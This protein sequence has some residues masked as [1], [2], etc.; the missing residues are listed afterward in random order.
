MECTL[1]A[2]ANKINY[3][4]NDLVEVC[5]QTEINCIEYI[6]NSSNFKQSCFQKLPKNNGN[7]ENDIP[8]FKTLQGL[9]FFWQ[10]IHI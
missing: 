4:K 10:M 9:F 7:F 8:I 1:G 2:I 5:G 3:R 6:K